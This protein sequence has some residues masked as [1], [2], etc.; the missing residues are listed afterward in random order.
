MEE[1]HWLNQQQQTFEK[2][3]GFGPN[4]K[5]LWAL[6]GVAQWTECWPEN[7]RVLGSIPSQGACLGCGPGPP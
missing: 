7:Q 4:K 5:E 6:A 2:H 1:L 3:L